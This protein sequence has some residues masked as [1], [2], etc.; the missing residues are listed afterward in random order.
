[1]YPEIWLPSDTEKGVKRHA[2]IYFVCGNPGLIE[3]YSDFLNNLRGFLQTS[4][5]ETAYDIYGRNL[6]GFSDDD[7]EP[8]E[9]G[10]EPWD[11]NGQIEGIYDDVAA[12]RVRGGD[13]AAGK[14][15][16]FVVLTGH[17]VG[18]FISVEIFHR[19]M[20]SP[21]RAP[22][23]NL[24]YGFLLFPTL[25]HIG[26]SPSGTRVEAV[27]R[28]L[29]ILDNVAHVGARLI[30]NVFPK[31]TLTWIVNRV[32][33]FTPLTAEVTARW[34][35]S[36]DGVRQAIHLGLSELEMIRE[37]RWG[38]ELWE[39]TEHDDGDGQATPKFFL[40]YGREDHWVANW[41]RD[42]IIERRREHGKRGGRTKIEV[43]E[44]D[45]PHAFCTKVSSSLAMA[46]SVH[47][48]IQEI[49]GGLTEGQEKE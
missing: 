31:A 6:L 48:W 29:P 42:E 15:Y 27:R 44:G 41:A 45:I 28:V 46:R 10:N 47:E 8:F 3:Y 9:Q 43:A 21:T 17:S 14:P 40:F 24:K 12:K 22:H 19:H 4:E 25:T 36:R 11:L 1:M 16:D 39:V 34:L 30:L 35:K 2:L 32:M 7:H 37:E 20:K 23:L 38:E 13:G 26:Q 33:G 49:D 18:S 5:V